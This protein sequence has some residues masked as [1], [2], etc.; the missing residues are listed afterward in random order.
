MEIESGQVGDRL[1]VESERVGQP[2][3]VG[4]IVEVLGKGDLVHY[5]VRWDDG[6]RTTV[7]PSVGSTTIVKA[8][9][10]PAGARRG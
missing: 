4:E 1:S 6:H 3:R 8:R 9:K 5:T 10:R 7:F 2:P